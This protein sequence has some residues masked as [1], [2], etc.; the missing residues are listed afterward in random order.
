MF[1][2]N[3]ERSCPC[4]PSVREGPAR[5]ARL[6]RQSVGLWRHHNARRL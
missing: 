1:E 6:R 2:T 4:L 3:V 5:H